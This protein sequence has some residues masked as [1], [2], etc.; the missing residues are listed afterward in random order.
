MN[1]RDGLPFV[2]YAYPT[3]RGDRAPLVLIGEAP[4]A[5]EVKQGRPFCGRAGKLLDQQLAVID[6]DR[7]ACLVANVFRYR[8]PDNKIDH[9]FASKRKAAAENVALDE[10]HGKFGSSFVR[11]QYAPEI[12]HL[13]DTLN[14]LK[15]RAI[16]VLGRVPL[17]ALTGREGLTALR[18]QKL[19]GR[20]SGVP[21]VPAYHPSYLARLINMD[22]NAEA[23]FRADL[24]LARDA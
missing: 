21:I 10:S 6:I 9:F 7:N 4:G 11:A 12:T 24:V 3:V 19:A 8:P 14:Q 1:S 20:I 22:K 2:D 15:P 23:T 16:V 13:L 5:D 17:W 18:G